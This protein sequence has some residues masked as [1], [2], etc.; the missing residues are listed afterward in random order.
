M[1]TV[2][3]LYFDQEL[4][5]QDGRGWCV[6]FSNQDAPVQRF[7]TLNDAQMFITDNSWYFMPSMV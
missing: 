4:K 5:E 7:A 3:L 2:C 1:I 6:R